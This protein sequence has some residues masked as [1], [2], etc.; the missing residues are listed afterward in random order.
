MKKIEA[1]IRKSKFS[2]VKKALISLKIDN[3]S[4]WLV[5]N[6]GEASE[7]R[8]YRGVEYETSAVERIK[9]ELVVN[10]NAK[11]IVQALVEAGITGESGDGRV[12]VTEVSEAYQIITENNL[13]KAISLRK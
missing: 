9:L 12:F 8:I 4:Y 11:E 13:D 7:S 1:I 5:R 10:D 3:F 2:E 6:V